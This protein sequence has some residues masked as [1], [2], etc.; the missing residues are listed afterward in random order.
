[1]KVCFFVYCSTTNGDGTT[2]SMCNITDKMLR[3]GAEV[4]AAPVST[5][6]LE[7]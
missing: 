2:L 1:M 5:R 6:N 3:R 7:G 4:V